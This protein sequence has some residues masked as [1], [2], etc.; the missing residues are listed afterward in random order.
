MSI[1][2]AIPAASTLEHL[3]PLFPALE[4]DVIPVIAGPCS[5]ESRV[6][7]LET[8]RQIAAT[9]CVSAFRAGLWKPR[10]HP[11]G[12][13]GVGAEGLAWLAEVKAAT[14]MPVAT[15]VAT[16]EHVEA[17]IAAGID[18]IWIGA[19]TSA[20]P[21]AVQE[22][23]DAL[24]TVANR[25]AVLVKNPV[26]PDIELWIG[27]LQ[28][29]RL[30]GVR[31]LAAVHRGFSA[32]GRHLYRNPPQWRIPIELKRRYP[33]LP[34]YCDPSHI[35]G[36][37]SL[38]GGVARK[39]MEIGF[40]GL[41]VESH[42]SPECA[43]SDKSQQLTPESLAALLGTLVARHG[44]ACATDDLTLMRRQIDQID[45]E[46]LSLLS[47]RMMVSDK[48]GTYKREHNMSVVQT[49]RYTALINRLGDAAQSLG[50][51]PDFVA[52]LFETIH[53]ES[54]RRQLSPE[55]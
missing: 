20:N 34:V 55:Q 14:G 16:R 31:R 15:E 28:R 53:E 37:R 47:Q 24:S 44:G 18:I 38:V 26:N 36:E 45:D 33:Q 39:A 49:T 6:Q 4:P 40:D 54:V 32:Y 17:A 1:E 42:C 7:V 43:L 27:A 8:A 30:A 3:S 50:L 10:T 22:I 13:E 46:L 23:A 29:I 5:A 21:F 11:G 2:R 12:F 48:I 19:R 41:I 35:G 25:V 51:A 9:G 52:A